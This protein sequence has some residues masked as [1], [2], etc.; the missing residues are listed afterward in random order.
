M[1]INKMRL[2]LAKQ[3]LYPLQHRQF[4]IAGVLISAY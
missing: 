3:M 1:N 2:F 4:S